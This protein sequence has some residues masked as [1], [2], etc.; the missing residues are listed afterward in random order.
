V[1]SRTPELSFIFVKP[2]WMR[3]VQDMPATPSTFTLFII[4]HKAS[5]LILLLHAD[6]IPS[7]GWLIC[8]VP[9]GVEMGCSHRE[10]AK[11]FCKH[12]L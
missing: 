1:F 7:H 10:V 3:K 4:G 8:P 12:K 11:V 9:W 2:W 6:T 5:T